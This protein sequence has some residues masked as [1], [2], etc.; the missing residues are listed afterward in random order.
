MT[1]VRNLF[2]RCTGWLTRDAARDTRRT[3]PRRPR[4]SPLRLETLESRTVLSPAVLDPNLT[5]RTVVSGLNQPTTMAFL[6]TNDFLVLEKTTGKVQHVVNGVLAGTVLDLPVNGASERGL[7]GIALSPNFS[8]DHNVFLYWT[9]SSTGADSLNLADVPLLGNRVDRFIWNGST[10]TFDRN[11][12]QLHA[13]QEDHNTPT[14][15]MQGNHNGG[16]IRFGPDGKLYIII[17]D[18]GRRGWMQNLVNGPF[19]PGIPDDQFGGPEPDFAHLTGVIIR[20]NP[21]GTTPTD[22]PFFRTA[23][24]V[25]DQIRPRV[26]DTVADQVEADLKKVYAYGVRNSFG[27][28]FDP[29]TGNLWEQENGDDAFDEINR[30]TPGQNNGWVQVMGPISRVAQFKAIETSTAIDPV[31]NTSYFGLQQARWSPN[32]IPDTPEQARKAL[33]MLPGAHYS[34]PVFSWKFAVAP[35]GLGF[36]NSSALGSQYRGDLFVGEARTF[37]DNGYLFD[38]HFKN[39]RKQFDFSDPRLKDGVADN[40]NK[41]DITESE[42]LLFGTGFGIATDIQTGPDGNLYVVSLSD[43]KV[44]EIFAKPATFQ[45]TNLVSDV[46]NPP[47]GAP[48]VQDANLKNPWGVS[49][50][51]QTPFWVSDQAAGV[52][53]LYTS[54][55]DGSTAAKVPLTVT[56]PPA[57][58]ATQGTPTGQVANTTTDFQLNGSPALFI[59]ASLDGNIT[60]WNRSAGT[61]AVVESPNPGSVYTGLAIGSSTAGN[62]LYA[63]NVAQGRIDVFDKNFQHATAPGGFLDPNLPPGVTTFVPFNVQNLG[64]TLY[65]TYENRADREHGGI[66]DAF[67]T[68]GNFLRRVVTGGVNAPWGL[69]IAPAT[70]GPFGGALLVGNF[71]LGD[72]KINAYNPM[73]GKFLGYVTD[74]NGL[75][76]AFERLWTLTFGNGVTGGKDVLFFTAGIN[77]EKDGLFGSIRFVAP[78]PPLPPPPGGHDED[79]GD[80]DDEGGDHG[81]GG[82]AQPGHSRGRTSPDLQVSLGD[83]LGMTGGTLANLAGSFDGSDW[84]GGKG[85]ASLMTPAGSD[86]FFLGRP[87]GVDAMLSNQPNDGV[88]VRHGQNPDDGLVDLWAM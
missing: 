41:F 19:G 16:I 32:N 2:A 66:V 9:Q 74:A 37:L 17:G 62:F 46:A 26:G 23:K 59:F 73:T 30:V 45:Q 70:F 27:M 36:L 72:G 53:T 81:D 11:L 21:D 48:V 52:T 18:N 76:L 13:F 6:G 82:M 60:A 25:A 29:L 50:G 54:N 87:G 79:E 7:L 47:G 12:I 5:V 68:S 35:A 58:P 86:P 56:I 57:P 40:N 8:N 1:R 38:F 43:G 65:V 49:F 31:T 22:N 55:A 85:A 67:D 20:L 77:A 33:F 84:S 15:P 14:A 63:A 39:N 51:P 64:G 75:P 61:T 10:L 69:A 34:D 3:R 44:Y 71:G 83:G 24:R 4:R 80:D 28:A 42:S 88:T 78:A